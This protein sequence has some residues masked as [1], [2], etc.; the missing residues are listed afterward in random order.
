MGKERQMMGDSY[1]AWLHPA[2]PPWPLN[3][4]QVMTEIGNGIY[5]LG[6]DQ[7]LSVCLRWGGGVHV[8]LL[9][10]HRDVWQLGLLMRG[11]TPLD[12]EQSAGLWD[13]GSLWCVHVRPTGLTVRGRPGSVR[14]LLRLPAAACIYV[15]I[16]YSF[17]VWSWLTAG[18]IYASARACVW[19]L[20]FSPRLHTYEQHRCVTVPHTHTHTPSCAN[21]H[22]CRR[23]LSVAVVL[24]ILSISLRPRARRVWCGSRLTL[25]GALWRS[26]RHFVL[27]NQCNCLCVSFPFAGH[28]LSDFTAVPL[29]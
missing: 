2:L 20:L 14:A 27:K 11:R 15:I 4:N 16:D 5:P 6:R 12:S 24:D 8:D 22:T 26:H 21:T 13:S 7:R 10:V 29:W 19:I 17:I 9:R 25:A 3:H 23:S 28:P 18:D 1:L